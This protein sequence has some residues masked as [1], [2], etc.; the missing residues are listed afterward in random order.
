MLILILA[1]AALLAFPILTTASARAEGAGAALHAD[2]QPETDSPEWVVNLPAA[3]NAKQLFV[4]AAIGEDQTTAWVTMHRRDENGIWKNIL[5]SPGF[6][7][8]E[9]LCADADHREG[10]SQTPAGVYRFTRAFGIEADPGCAI[11]YF[12]VNEYTCWSGDPER[13]YNQMVDLREVPDLKMDDS[14]RIIDYEYQ[15]RYCLNI[16]FNEEGTP[17]RGSAIFLHCFGRKHPWTGGCV[18][19]PENIM[20]LIMQK[21]QEDCVVVIDSMKNLNAGF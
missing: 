10:C 11:P 6:I 9:G 14:E 21:V 7:G 3:E 15:Y 2:I 5:S 4:V 8:K 12:Q 20:K 18:A 13:F 19:V 17:G 1:V 16:G